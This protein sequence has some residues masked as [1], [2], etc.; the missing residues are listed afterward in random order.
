MS[1]EFSESLN[2]ICEIRWHGRGGQGAIT[3]A[4]YLAEAAFLGGFKGVTSAPSF[5]AERRGA[6]VTAS[7]RMS[8]E[9]LRVLSQVEHPDVVIVLDDTLLECADATAGL[10]DNGWVIVNSPLEP[11]ALGLDGHFRV[12]T[13]DATAVAH[14]AG[15]VVAGSVMVN[16]AML[17]AVA[18]A[19]GLVTLDDIRKTLSDKFSPA[20]AEKNFLAAR[21]T[22]ERTKV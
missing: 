17:G 11:A 3:S 15:M 13:A 16:T 1:N 2:G 22:Y 9:P 21:L 8:K 14:E 7:T 18:R 5:G 6:P 19:T 10:K 12:A 20:V 4:K